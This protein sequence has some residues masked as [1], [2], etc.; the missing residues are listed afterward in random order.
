MKTKQSSR[1]RK[2]LS[3]NKETLVDLSNEA[4]AQ[5]P[6]GGPWSFTG[7]KVFQTCLC[8]Q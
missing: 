2:T 7:C 8:N 6:G 3:L 4:L 1:P 5:V